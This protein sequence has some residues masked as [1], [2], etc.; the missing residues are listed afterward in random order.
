MASEG[1]PGPQLSPDGHWWWDGQAWQPV[2]APQPP[3][4]A[5]APAPAPAAAAASKPEWLDQ[6]PSWLAE[7]P[8]VAAPAPPPAA[9]A[10]PAPAP[11]WQTPPGSGRS[12][13]VYIA[14]A[15]L[16]AVIGLGAFVVRGQLAG[17]QDNVAT[18]QVSPSPLI[19]D[20]ERADRFLNIDLGPSLTETTNA[21]PGVESQCTSSLPPGCK[22]ALIKL[23]KAMVDV[24]DAVTQNQRDIP[25]CI[26][27]AVAQF[28]YDW[29]G[30]EQGVSQAIQG[31]Q[32]NSRDMIISGLQK[33]ASIAQFLKPDVDRIDAA[34]KT[35][36]K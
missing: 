30:M 19:S 22:D 7:P 16:I 13:V 9:V 8:G 2:R 27:P 33:F 21:L 11:M 4:P 31:Y 29:N 14:A 26:G 18:T 23:D 25:G 24:Q 35:C 10:E 5:P 15:L 28:K 17:N 32:A 6:A 1:V 3:Q 20:Y 34:Q 12:P 36:Q